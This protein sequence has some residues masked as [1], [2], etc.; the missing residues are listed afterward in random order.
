VGT[1]QD[2][3]AVVTGGSSGIGLAIARQL[4]AQG[5][6]VSLVARRPEPLAEAV[7]ALT[8]GGHRAQSSAVDVTDR[9]AVADAIERLTSAFGPCD[10][11]VT[12]AGSV[13]PGHFADLADDVFRDTM[14]VDY[15]GTLWPIRAVV[16][17]MV[18]R[19]TG[20]IVGVSSGAGLIGIYGYSAYTPAKFAVRGL[21]E[22]L[23]CELAP[24]GVHVGCVCPPDTDTPQLA[25]ENQYKPR[26]TAAIS[27][28]IKPI[29][30]DRVAASVLRGIARRRFLITADAQTGLLARVAGLVPG[31]LH[32]SFDKKVRKVREAS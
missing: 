29:S 32:R 12:S 24:Y 1:F 10:V 2:R 15:F 4:A 19:R 21:L 16:P 26:E 27:G 14:E 3:H 5:A 17:S 18:E 25:F 30:A 8:A 28:A 22:V 13:L 11:L 31:T 7:A 9:S 20:S 6:A 23:R